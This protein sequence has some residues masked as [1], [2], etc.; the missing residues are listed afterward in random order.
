MA[1]HHCFLSSA[2]QLSNRQYTCTPPLKPPLIDT[3]KMHPS[4][5]WLMEKIQRHPPNCPL[6]GNSVEAPLP[7]G[8]NADISPFG[9]G[10]RL[11]APLPDDRD[12]VDEG[13][14]WKQCTCTHVILCNPHIKGTRCTDPSPDKNKFPLSDKNNNNAAIWWKQ[15]MHH[16]PRWEQC[17]GT[18]L[19]KGTM[20]MQHPLQQ[21]S[22]NFPQP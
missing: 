2:Y 16:F 22:A 14:G 9:K 20:Q 4:T 19:L 12:N 18:P 3:M 15:C 5:L 21:E 7:W 10:D 13:I 11:D 8:N 1:H 17:R 6:H